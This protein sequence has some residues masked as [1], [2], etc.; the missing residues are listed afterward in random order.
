MRQEERQLLRGGSAATTGHDPPGLSESDQHPLRGRPGMGGCD[1][2]AAHHPRGV[3]RGFH[4][5]YW[6]LSY[7]RKF[8][9]TLWIV[10][11]SPTL[12]LFPERMLGHVQVVHFSFLFLDQPRL[13]GALLRPQLRSFLGKLSLCHTYFAGNRVGASLRARVVPAGARTRSPGASR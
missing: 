2:C 6:G 7:R 13:G 12:L 8:L 5:L 4:F 11:L 10:G 3:D 1:Y 9:R